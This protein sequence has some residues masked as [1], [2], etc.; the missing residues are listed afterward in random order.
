MKILFFGTDNYASLVL[1]KLLKVKL[2]VVG[3]IRKS[4]LPNLDLEFEPVD[5][6]AARQQIPV[7][8][9]ASK[10]ELEEILPQLSNLKP[11]I[12]LVA[13][14]GAVIPPKLFNLPT[15]NTLNLHPSLLPKYRG[16]APVEQAILDARQKTGITLLE[17][18]DKLDAGDIIG[19]RRMEF[20]P[21][22]TALRVY[23]KLYSLGVELFRQVIR[24]FPQGNFPRRSQDEQL[25]TYTYLYSRDDAR[26]DWQAEPEQIYRVIR[27]FYPKP[28]AWSYLSE[29]VNY[30]SRREIP[31]SW[32]N[33]R[34]KVFKAQVEGG[35]VRPVSLQV[36]GKQKV[37]WRE[38]SRGYLPPPHRPVQ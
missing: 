15:Y 38:F 27:A 32:Q 3:V 14:Y 19:Q 16:P 34:V 24:K 5:R 20:N 21:N 26:I 8:Q 29:L 31:S 11:E 13:S 28:I 10:G 23:K 9:A 25:A 6:L 37:G 2:E 36:E 33:K 35:R 22:E 1:R 4:G 12:G 7:F 18:G 17:L 30:Y